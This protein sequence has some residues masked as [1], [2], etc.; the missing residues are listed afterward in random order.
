M[1]NL[2][3]SL[4]Q[5]FMNRAQERSTWVGLMFVLSATGVHLTPELQEEII[6]AGLAAAGAILAV[7]PDKP[8]IITKEPCDC[9]TKKD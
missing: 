3:N 7:V 9:D 5:M 1:Q 6:K 4:I 2:I 8:K